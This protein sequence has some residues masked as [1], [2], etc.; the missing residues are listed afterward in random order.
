MA[1]KS[2]RKIGKN[3]EHIRTRA[4]T[5]KSSTFL[6][7][8]FVFAVTF[9]FR[10]A[11]KAIIQS[12]SQEEYSHGYLIP[13]LALLLLL[14]KIADAKIE[15]Q[16]SW[17]G[18]F[19]I[20]ASVAAA[21]FFQ[22][23]G[24]THLLPILYVISIIG[25]VT[26]FLGKK[27]I[28]PLAGPLILLFFAVP[29]PKFFYY[30]LSSHMQMVSTSL[31]VFFLNL[32]DVPVLQD[33]NII[34]L[35]GYKLNVV[36]ACSGVRYLFPLLSLSFLLAYMYRAPFWKRAVLFVSAIPFAILLNGARIALVGVTVDRWGQKMAEGFI[37]DFEGF[38]IFLI[39]FLLLLL[40]IR[41]LQ[42]VG[43]KGALQ[44]D[45]LRI[46]SPKS[47]PHPAT[48][49]PSTTCAFFLMIAVAISAVLPTFLP[50]Y[51]TPV[52]L[53]QPFSAFPLR[54]G[55]WA[56]Q[57]GKSLDKKS[58]DLLGTNDYL[59]ADFAKP[60]ATPVDIY[61]L[62]FPQEDSTSNEAVHTPTVCIPGGGWTV[63]TQ[64]IKTIPVNDPSALQAQP[65]TVN[66]LL[67]SKDSAREVVYYWYAQSN[68]SS[69][70]V[71]SA[72]LHTLMNS[73]TQGHTNGALLRFITSIERGETEKDAET[74][75]NAFASES[76]PTLHTYMFGSKN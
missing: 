75:L 29:L 70:N 68:Y 45:A 8:I 43:A 57:F 23:T 46:S 72:R 49:G 32:L 60:A 74:R 10:D 20:F 33:G 35:G 1:G 24:I 7:L 66:E 18:F 16:T 6:F 12:W 47:L 19:I 41:V 69:A 52:Y 64:A 15:P 71:A 55:G 62:Y 28:G 9:I 14:N 39:G 31:G 53:S 38:V 37:H 44:F 5:L 30:G 26:L 56:G 65:L 17:L 54:I 48:G 67:I 13:P 63:E 58:L 36:E 25:L 22:F 76:L 73:L 34:D 2:G 42:T 40:E 3:M 51:L 59:L 27:A 11:S 21:F 4:F 50:R 61:V